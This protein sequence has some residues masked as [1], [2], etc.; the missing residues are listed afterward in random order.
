MSIDGTHI[1][2]RHFVARKYVKNN[3]TISI[4]IKLQL[5]MVVIYLVDKSI[6]HKRILQYMQLLINV[7]YNSWYI[8]ILATNDD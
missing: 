8:V 2:T 3:F 7:I 4:S 1:R 5:V 6:E